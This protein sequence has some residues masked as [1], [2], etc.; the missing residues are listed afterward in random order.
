MSL[1][2]SYVADLVHQAVKEAEDAV[3]RAV[4][5]GAKAVRTAQQGME[6]TMSVFITWA[7]RHDIDIDDALSRR[8]ARMETRFGNPGQ[9]AGRVIREGFRI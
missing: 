2:S 9:Q 5:A 1:R 7:A 3:K 8:D 6:E 4:E